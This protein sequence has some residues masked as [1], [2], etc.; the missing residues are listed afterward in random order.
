MELC[1]NPF[2]GKPGNEACRAVLGGSL[3][4]RNDLTVLVVDE[5]E[6]A[7]KGD[8]MRP[9]NSLQC[10]LVGIGRAGSGDRLCFAARIAGDVLG[11]LQHD[12]GG[13]FAQFRGVRREPA[14]DGAVHELKAEQK[15]ENRWRERDEGGAEHHAG[16]KT[17]AKRAAALICV[18]L[19]DGAQQ[20]QKKNKEGK[21]DDDGEAGEGQG[22]AGG[23]RIEEAGWG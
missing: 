16:A 12:A 11:Q 17:S 9:E 18:E 7:L 4:A 23:L 20:K 2:F 15:H 13:V 19:E 14:V 8:A 3:E 6:S 10:G 21:E 5:D 22:F 1:G